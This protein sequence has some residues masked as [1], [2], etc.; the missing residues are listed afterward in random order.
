MNGRRVRFHI[1]LVFTR[2]FHTPISASALSA[3]AGAEQQ[4]HG[5]I[6]FQFRPGRLR[7][8]EGDWTRELRKGTAGAAE[9]DGA[10][11]R[12]EGGQEGAGE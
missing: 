12:H 11:L 10:D 8:V 4:G 1:L 9:E 3:T 7:S 6:A 2:R 5:K